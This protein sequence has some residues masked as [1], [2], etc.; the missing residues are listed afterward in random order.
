MD[1]PTISTTA[2]PVALTD[3]SESSVLEPFDQPQIIRAQHMGF[4][5]GV[6]DALL[7]ADQAQRPE[8]TAIYGELVHNKDVTDSL[9]DQQF[10]ILAET[11]RDTLPQRPVVMV[12]AHGIS[13]RRKQ[14]LLDAGKE[15]IDTTC[16][17]V[18]RVHEAA[19]MLSQRGFFVV[20]IG[21]PGH[22]EVQGIVEDLPDNRWAVIQGPGA[23]RHFDVDQIGIVCQTTMPESIADECRDAVARLNPKS[24]IRFVNTVCRPTKQRQAAVDQLCKQVP[25]VIVVGGQNSNNT[26]RLVQ[27][28]QSH[29]CTA[30]HVQ[31]ADDIR[32]DWIRGQSRIGLTA[33]TSTPDAT[34][35]AV[36]SRLRNLAATSGHRLKA[37]GVWCHLWTNRQWIDYFNRNLQDDPKIPWSTSPT[38]TGA[39]LSLIHI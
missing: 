17:L 16:P 23:A 1:N 32:P 33:G 26:R 36:E 5:F 24:A 35:D 9:R 31:S 25:I 38:L 19:T 30:H 3:A 18:N 14:G 7:A 28:C 6:R 10:E 15:L 12:T 27:R 22:V 34:I 4:C 39:E 37:G 2:S 13:N 8:Q 20:V 29:G 11:N 21:K